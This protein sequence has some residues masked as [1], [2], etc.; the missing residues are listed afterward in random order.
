MAAGSD[1]PDSGVAQRKGEVY[2]GASIFVQPPASE[3]VALFSTI[4]SGLD[5]DSETEGHRYQRAELSPGDRIQDADLSASWSE[6]TWHVA[7]SDLGLK[8]CTYRGDATRR[9]VDLPNLKEFLLAHAVTPHRMRSSSS[10]RVGWSVLACRFG[11]E[12]R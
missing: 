3:L 12:Q 4:E 9:V 5:L 1:P 2:K 7:T 10:A 6:F 11:N 8:Q